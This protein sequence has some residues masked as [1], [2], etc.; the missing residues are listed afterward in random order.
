MT[1]TTQKDLEIQFK[2]GVHKGIEREII[3]AHKNG[4]INLVSIKFNVKPT[5]N[6]SWYIVSILPI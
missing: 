3:A 2:Y 6:E 5:K 4:A 1:W